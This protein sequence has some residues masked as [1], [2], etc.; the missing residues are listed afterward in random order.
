M[1]TISLPWMNIIRDNKDK[2]SSKILEILYN[3]GLDEEARIT[4]TFIE[5]TGKQK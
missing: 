3:Y 5:K 4:K 2:E 1:N